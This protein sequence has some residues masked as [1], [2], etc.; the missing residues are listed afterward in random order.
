MRLL[1]I[2][3][4]SATIKY[5]LRFIFL[6]LTDLYILTHMLLGE[7]NSKRPFVIMLETS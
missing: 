6:I 1:T 4:I 5:L 3:F 2:A 7:D